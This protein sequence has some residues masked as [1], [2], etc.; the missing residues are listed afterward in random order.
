MEFTILRFL[1]G[2]NNSKGK[3]RFKRLQ[4][5][6]YDW[7]E[8]HKIPILQ[9]VSEIEFIQCH[10]GDTWQW[11]QYGYK[12]KEMCFIDFYVEIS[13]ELLKEWNKVHINKHIPR[14]NAKQWD[15]IHIITVR[16]NTKGLTEWS[17][18]NI[19][20]EYF[21]AGRNWGFRDKNEAIYFGMIW[22]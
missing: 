16:K 12:Q 15:E 8:N 9:K 21:V 10:K 14:A 5:V 22:K 3:Q 19:K 1:K 4:P 13:D 18:K 11:R 2:K 17:R 6:R 20:E 7:L